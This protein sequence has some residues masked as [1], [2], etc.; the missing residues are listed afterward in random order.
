MQILS[1]VKAGEKVASS[2]GY[3]IDSEAQLK[4]GGGAHAGH[5]GM[6]MEEKGAPAAAPAA[7]KKKDDMKMD[8]MKM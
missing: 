8:D 6:K 7:P 2:G 5:E 1:G 4:G 3:L